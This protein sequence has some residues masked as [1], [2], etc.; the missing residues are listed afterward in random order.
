[1]GVPGKESAAKT[2]P[3]NDDNITAHRIGSVSSGQNGWQDFLN[4]KQGLWPRGN[5]AKLL[6]QGENGCTLSPTW[7]ATSM[8]LSSLLLTGNAL[9]LLH[10]NPQ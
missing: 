2:I 6:L 1:M 7:A 9:R 8:G 5:L 10:F 4:N 3:N